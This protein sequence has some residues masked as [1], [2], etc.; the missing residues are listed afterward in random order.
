MEKC[1]QYTVKRKKKRRL[2]SNHIQC[3]LIFIKYIC[4]YKNVKKPLYQNF[5]SDHLSGGILDD[6]KFS[7]F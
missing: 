5:N 3:D 6:L 7:F 2:Q 1:S 4:I